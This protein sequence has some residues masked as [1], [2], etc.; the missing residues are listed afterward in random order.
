MIGNGQ[1]IGLSIARGE[2]GGGGS[3]PTIFWW[4]LGTIFIL[5]MLGFWLIDDRPS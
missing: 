3:V 5:A 4:C 1:M 2:F